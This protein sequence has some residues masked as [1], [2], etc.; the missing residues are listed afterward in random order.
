[1]RCWFVRHDVRSGQ[2]L[3]EQ[4]ERGIYLHDRL[5]LVL[6]EA[7]MSSSWVTTEIASARQKER[8]QGRTV[9]F[10]TGLVPFED[11]RKWRVF[12]A[13]QGTDT[14]REVREFYIPDF[15][16]W[17]HEAKYKAAFERLLKD[18][19]VADPTDRAP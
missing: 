9:L 4:I 13:D 12:D 17:S 18:L 7:N 15:S 2:K 19:R 11:V 3:H 6:S 16:D 5:L 1:M 8:E 14:G 10:P